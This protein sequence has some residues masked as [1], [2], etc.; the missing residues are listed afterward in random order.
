MLEIYG[1]TIWFIPFHS[2]SIVRR[3]AY[4]AERDIVYQFRSSASLSV[5]RRQVLCLNK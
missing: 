4:H 1:I 2:V 3:H 5:E